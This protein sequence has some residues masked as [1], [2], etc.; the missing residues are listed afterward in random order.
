[1]RAFDFRLPI[2][3]AYFKVIKKNLPA[4]SIY[5]LF[6]LAISVLAAKMGGTPTSNFETIKSSV[7]FYDSDNTAFTKGLKASLAKTA[8]FVQ[9]KDDKTAQ[10]DALFAHEIQV[11]IRIPKGYTDQFLA[12]KQVKIEKTVGQN[13]FG[14]QSTDLAI[15]RYLSTAQLYEKGMPGQSQAELVKNVQNS[16]AKETP[17]TTKSYGSNVSLMAGASSYFG[18]LAYVFIIIIFMGISSISMS[19]SDTEITKRNRVSPVRSSA[20]GLQLFVGHILF[21]LVVFVCGLILSL[22]ILGTD[23]IGTGYYFL[24]LNLLCF[25]VVCVAIGFLISSFVHNHGAQN[26]IA[27]VLSLGLAFVG[28][29]FIP[30]SLLSPTMLSIARFTP[31]F[32][33]VKAANEIGTLS[34]F[35]AGT[36]V[37]VFAS[38]G[39]ELGFAAALF[40]VSMALLRQKKRA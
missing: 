2:L 8:D 5:I 20:M 10:A 11:I 4:L 7:A 29:I 12:G 1:M 40:A 38:M 14:G 25:T 26:G 39:I 6:F 34:S 37:P 19:F 28:G 27:N 23:V 22:F 31:S 9:I 33:Y 24:C 18:Y 3:A 36:L 35:N 13:Q 17:V 15:Q 21:A 32:W 16:I 30:Q